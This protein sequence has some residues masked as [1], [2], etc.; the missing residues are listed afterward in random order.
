MVCCWWCCHEIDGEPLSL[1]Y[2]YSERLN[3]F[4]TTGYFCSW[5]CMKSF[6]L[7]HYPFHKIPVTSQNITLLRKRSGGKIESVT[8]APSRYALKKFGGPLSIEEFRKNSTP[9]IKYNLPSD[10]IIHKEISESKQII[11]HNS[12]NNECSDSTTSGAQKLSSIINSNAKQN[13]SLKL[14]RETPLKRDKNNLETTLGLSRKKR[15]QPPLP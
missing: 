14:K 2:K 8:P 13:Q 6:N 1:P 3:Q 7:D 15:Q 12:T 5:S 9:S 11:V 10:M 4:H